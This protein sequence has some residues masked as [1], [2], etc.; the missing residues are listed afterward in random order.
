MRDA[1]GSTAA[2]RHS[3]SDDRHQAVTTYDRNLVIVAGAGTGKTSLLVERILNQV[4][5]QDLAL[6]ELA[7]I[8]FTDKAATE[9]RNRLEAGLARL[10]ALARERATA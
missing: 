3:D 10:A 5:E 6:S 7:A 9:M 1:L 4:V 8:T 2:A